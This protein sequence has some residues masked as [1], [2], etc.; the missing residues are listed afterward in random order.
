MLDPRLE[1][2]QARLGRLLEQLDDC[3]LERQAHTRLALLSILAGHHMLMIGPPGTAKSLLARAVCRC[4]EGGRYFEYLLSRFT[5]PDELFGPVSIPGLKQE[6]YRRLTDGYLPQAHVAFLDEIFKAN[7][8]IL[9][10]L[11]TLV[12]ERIF[13]HGTHRDTVP[14][15]GMLGASNEPP[16]SD[17]LDALYDRFLIRMSVLPL[18][19]RDHFLQVCLGQV[20]DFDPPEADRLTLDDLALIRTLSRQVTATEEAQN[21]LVS[22]REAFQ[23]EEIHASDRRWRQA[24]DL[25]K[26]GA[27]TSGRMHLEAV[28][29]LLLQYC[30]GTPGE[31]DTRVHRLVCQHVLGGVQ[32]GFD[33]RPMRT[34]SAHLRQR[35][36]PKVGF[37]GN[38]ARRLELL[39]E[40]AQRCNALEGGVNSRR[41]DL[42]N[43]F[44]LSRWIH[45][46][47]PE[48]FTAMIAARSTLHDD[49]RPFRALVDEYRPTL[50][51]FSLVEHFF[52][53]FA[54]RNQ[55][56]SVFF[57]DD[58]NHSIAW[59]KAPGAAP[60]T[61]IGLQEEGRLVTD[62][63]KIATAQ[64]SAARNGGIWHQNVLSIE[65]T[66]DLLF[67]VRIHDTWKPHAE[68]WLEEIWPAERTEVLPGWPKR[69]VLEASLMRLLE[70]LRV[71]GGEIFPVPAQNPG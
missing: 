46:V 56:R 17:A 37:E 4:I 23:N 12:N 61:W 65:V 62:P 53:A 19:S 36:D 13:H 9:N 8:A 39:D 50:E 25:L 5:H 41:D 22:L 67:N 1:P 42:L 57:Y 33:L 38:K 58:D 10:S 31:T 14:L 18:A 11:L 35:P 15:L 34:I 21:V 30:F 70:D 52:N 43:N 40:L 2:I 44:Q 26:V 71:V 47:P 27:L 3:F 69:S 45:E 49:L 54:L 63:N 28:D 32:A 16:E 29:L 64:R 68:R 7:S 6:D 51:A 55:V 59:M 66:D 60:E 48:V 20:R 24:V